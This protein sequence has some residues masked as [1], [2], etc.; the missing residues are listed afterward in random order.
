MTK[1]I[2][3]MM[4]EDFKTYSIENNHTSKLDWYVS[5][6]VSNIDIAHED[7]GLKLDYYYKTD[8]WDEASKDPDMLV[9]A[10]ALCNSGVKRPFLL[11]DESKIRI[12]AGIMLKYCEDMITVAGT[13]NNAVNPL[14]EMSAGEL[15][16]RM[17]GEETASD[18]MGE[19][20]EVIQPMYKPPEQALDA[21]GRPINHPGFQQQQQHHNGPVQQPVT[22][23]DLHRWDT[24]SASCADSVMLFEGMQ[25]I[26]DVKRK[27]TE[28]W[29]DDNLD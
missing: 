28:F 20:V 23:F 29:L 7:I 19:F 24:E 21:F 9:R 10:H 8:L 14:M 2:Q 12:L 17:I 6:L 15:I 11:D 25:G 26:T 3:E 13:R 22:H 5:H 1:R 16:V 4:L 18:Y 27:L